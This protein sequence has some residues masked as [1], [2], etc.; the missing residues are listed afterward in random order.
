MVMQTVTVVHYIFLLR[1]L[2]SLVLRN[3]NPC[4]LDACESLSFQ[5][6]W[7]VLVKQTVFLVSSLATLQ[8][9]NGP[10]LESSVG[11]RSHRITDDMWVDSSHNFPAT[12]LY[13]ITYYFISI[14]SCSLFF[15]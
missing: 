9:R 3:S 4:V 14:S 15:L 7:I 8:D 13:E 10:H 11:G 2:S 5:P 6:P 12:D 1:L